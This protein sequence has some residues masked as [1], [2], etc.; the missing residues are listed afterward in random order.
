MKKLTFFLVAVMLL[1]GCSEAMQTKAE[2]EQVK[3]QTEQIKAKTEQETQGQ[4][5]R[6]LTALVENLSD[7]LDAERERSEELE[8]KYHELALEAIKAKRPTVWPWIVSGVSLLCVGVVAFIALGRRGE[9]V[10]MIAPRPAGQWLPQQ[11]E[12]LDIV[13][14]DQKELVLE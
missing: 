7:A 4:V 2:T 6:N 10:V 11:S 9:R 8:E 5:M 13:P 14:S 3:A 12:T 1:T